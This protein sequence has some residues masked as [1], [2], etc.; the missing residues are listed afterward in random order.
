MPTPTRRLVCIVRMLAIACLTLALVT[1]TAAQF[2]GLKKKAQQAAGSEAA[3]KAGDSTAAQ[4]GAAPAPAAGGGGG[5]TETVVLD[6]QLVDQ[7]ITGLKAGKAER[8]AAK[9]EN[10]PYG[11]YN[12]DAAAYEAAKDKCSQAQA[13][14]P[15]RAVADPKFS[16]RYS[17]ATE[18]MVKA[19]EAGNQE[20]A[21]AWGDSAL[22][23]M[24][25]SCIVKQPKQ[26]DDYYDAQRKID[27]RAEEQ[28]IKSSKMSRSEFAMAQERTWMI[29][30][31]Q[32]PP[33][34]ASASEKT[35]VNN[36]S[37]E[38][39]SLMGLEQPPA[40]AAKPASAPTAAPAPAAA[41]APSGM[42]DD[43]SKVAN[44]MANNAQKHEKEIEALG[45]RAQ[46]A[47]EANDMAKTMAIADTIRQ[48]QSAGCQ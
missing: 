42:S 23:M 36:R 4:K 30:Q 21:A 27:S 31:G 26:P 15:N 5:G 18:K 24:D 19:Q 16:D 14:F 8:E 44:C 37:A 1:P 7:F 33:G 11:Q 9:K 29:L 46:A 39:K 22:A 17:A 45:T 43:Q 3:K 38:L 13:T 2:G 47:A 35:A 41:A 20:L 25:P 28:A 48:L 10:T 6:D 40:R 32:T 34:D 12:R